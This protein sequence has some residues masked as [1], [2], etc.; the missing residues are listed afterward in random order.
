MVSRVI[1]GRPP[2][3][4]A[5]HQ[6]PRPAHCGERPRRLQLTWLHS[7]SR[8]RGRRRQNL[9]ACQHCPVTSFWGNSAVQQRQWM[10]Y[11][12]SLSVPLHPERCHLGSSCEKQKQMGP[13]YGE[14]NQASCFLCG[15][16][17]WQRG[18]G[19][20]LSPRLRAPSG[21]T[22]PCGT[23]LLCSKPEWGRGSFSVPVWTQAGDSHGG[24]CIQ[25]ASPCSWPRPIPGS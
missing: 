19:G 14:T 15:Q 17:W 20:F 25:Q 9:S 18:R 1:Y 24:P 10:G 5:G 8:L 13:A 2:P 3:C 4:Q 22:L 16:R 11:V 21:H 6:P 7:G 23:R 12:K